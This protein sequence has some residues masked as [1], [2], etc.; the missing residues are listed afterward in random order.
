MS[1][2]GV[3][4]FKDE[5]DSEPVAYIYKHT[6]NY[7]EG[8]HGAI[9]GIL[10]FFRE[11]ECH[12]NDTRFDDPAYL[13]AKFVVFWAH[14]YARNPEKYLNFLSVGVVGPGDWGQQYTYDIICNNESGRP[15]FR[16]PLEHRR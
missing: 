1:I 14:E 16:G 9:V 11:V 6:D 7:P 3:Y 5:P 8:K 13:A 2:G 4:R 12:T 15:G 10:R